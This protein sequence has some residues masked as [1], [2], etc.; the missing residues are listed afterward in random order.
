[1]A[2]FK[3]KPVVIEAVQWDGSN[4][5]ECLTWIGIENVD[6]K[7]NY[8][9]I[10]TL[11]DACVALGTT[12]AEQFPAEAVKHMTDDE[13][14]YRELKIVAKALNQA[15][16]TAWEPDW[17]NDDEVKYFPWMEVDTTD[18]NKAGSG[19]SSYVCNFGRA[20]TIVG[21]RLCFKKRELALYAGKQFSEMYKRF[22]LISK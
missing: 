18:G 1:M 4:N 11:E 9:N 3:K 12:V 20:R 6:N 16:G 22:W 10:K 14:A 5:E 8:P 7:L 13:V 19:F 17:S 21:S 15:D 2:K